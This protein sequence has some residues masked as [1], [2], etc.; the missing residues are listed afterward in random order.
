MHLNAIH[1]YLRKMGTQEYELSCNKWVDL[2]PCV[3]LPFCFQVCVQRRKKENIILIVQLCGSPAVYNDSHVLRT[4]WS[5]GDCHYTLQDRHITA[6]VYW[7][8]PILLVFAHLVVL[9]NIA[10]LC[11][12]SENIDWCSKLIRCVLNQTLGRLQENGPC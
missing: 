3:S 10:L 4:V 11:F 7:S 12:A 1:K 9:Q 2:L 8:Y 6:A 5:A